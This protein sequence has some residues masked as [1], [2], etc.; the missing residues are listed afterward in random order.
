MSDEE[1]KNARTLEIEQRLSEISDEENALNFEK[2]Q[3]EEEQ[4]QIV[5]V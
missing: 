4:Q 5:N 1:E 3:L 2:E